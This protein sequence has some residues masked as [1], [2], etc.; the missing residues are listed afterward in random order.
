MRLI[1]HTMVPSREWDEPQA[2]PTPSKLLS[3]MSGKHHSWQNDVTR[4]FHQPFL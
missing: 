2:W 4:V 3:Q 1:Q